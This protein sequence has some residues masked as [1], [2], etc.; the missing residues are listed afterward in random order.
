MPNIFHQSV[1][2]ILRAAT[3]E[4]KI[5]WNDIFLRF[6]ERCAISQLSICGAIAGLEI[7][8]YVARK[9]YLPYNLTLFGTS[10]AGV[11]TPFTTLY[12]E[13]NAVKYV[14]NNNLPAWDVTAA[15]MRYVSNTINVPLI[16]FSRITFGG[17]STYV[18][19]IGYRII[20]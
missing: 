18:N 15:A 19:F 14:A 7:G 6:G 20:Y 13:S 3:P 5:V 11:A 2:D 12:D 4:Q 8:T 9:I 16:Y 17:G 10:A 1:E